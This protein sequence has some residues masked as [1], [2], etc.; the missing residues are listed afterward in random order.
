MTR[1]A[2]CC[3]PGSPGARLS[4]LLVHPAAS[5]RTCSVGRAHPPSPRTQEV[6]LVGM[7]P[8]YSTATASASTAAAA[9][10]DAPDSISITGAVKI[11]GSGA[12]Q[13]VA[14]NN[15]DVSIARGQFVSIIGPSGC[16]K[17]TLLRLMAGLEIADEGSA[18]VFGVSPDAA[19][20]AKMIGLVPQAP[21]LLPWLDVLGNVSLPGKVNRGADRRRRRISGHVEK[22]A[23]DMS[24]LLRKVGLA[25]AAHKLPSQ[26][27][28]GMQQRTA[29]VRAFGLQPDVLLMDE[30]FSA[31]D[32]FT[33]EAIQGQLLDIWDQQKT[34]VV[35]VT[36]SVTEAVRLSDKVLVM[37]ARPGRITASIDITLPRPRSQDM[38][39]TGEFHHF[40]DVIRDHLQSAWDQ[41]P[42]TSAA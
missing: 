32:E 41:S 17:S 16:G 7:T 29:I 3:A 38:M 28:G 39:K 31:L 42:I 26:L 35:F 30:P 18:S 22:A 21:A 5:P 37:S 14:L 10:P 1:T 8:A 4:G 25:D 15:V 40:E 2:V 19:C 34:T 6:G 24:D 36:H 13:Q 23:P 33:R 9:S 11:Y 12:E 27:S 20:A